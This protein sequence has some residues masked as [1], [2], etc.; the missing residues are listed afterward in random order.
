MCPHVNELHLDENLC[1][2]TVIQHSLV[3]TIFGNI[4]RHTCISTGHCHW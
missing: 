2:V 4:N 1:V 3:N